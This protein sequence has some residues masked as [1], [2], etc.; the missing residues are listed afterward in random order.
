LAHDGVDGVV[1]DFAVGFEE[2]ELFEDV[3]DGL[4]IGA[5]GINVFDDILKNYHSFFC[6]GM[7]VPLT[8]FSLARC[9]YLFRFRFARRR[10]AALSPY[11]PRTGD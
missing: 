4:I 3:F 9:R 5:K 6:I 7:G 1:E 8:Y 10:A 11:Y 2:E